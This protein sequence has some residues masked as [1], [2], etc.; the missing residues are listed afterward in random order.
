MHINNDSIVNGSL[1]NDH[2]FFYKSLTFKRNTYATHHVVQI[3]YIFSSKGGFILY[4]M[5]CNVQVILNI[6]DNMNTKNI[7]IVYVIG[8]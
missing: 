4:N 6:N 1:H 2:I 3:T 7:R 5:M 8:K